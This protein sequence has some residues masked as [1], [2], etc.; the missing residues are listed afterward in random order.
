MEWDGE[1][2]FENGHVLDEAECMY[3]RPVKVV[4]T[5]NRVEVHPRGVT[6]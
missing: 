4:Q 2:R 5:E 6:A 3:G 1:C